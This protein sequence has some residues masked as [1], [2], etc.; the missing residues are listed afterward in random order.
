M[1]FQVDIKVNLGK[2]YLKIDK[3]PIKFWSTIY[4]TY[5]KEIHSKMEKNLLVYKDLS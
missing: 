3:D 4:Q 1:N 5:D 2:P